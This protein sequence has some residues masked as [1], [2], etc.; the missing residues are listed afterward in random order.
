MG[1]KVIIN[2]IPNTDYQPGKVLSIL[3]GVGTQ[4]KE[5]KIVNIY[6]S[7]SEQMIQMPDVTQLSVDKAV[8]I[9]QSLN[10]AFDISNIEAQYDI[11]K[12]L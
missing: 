9:L 5:G 11:Q 12:I 7:T 10:I 1:L 8:S 4:V 6:I 3:P 2:K